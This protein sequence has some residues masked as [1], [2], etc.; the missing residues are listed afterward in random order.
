M[1]PAS[2]LSRGLEPQGAEVQKLVAKDLTNTQIDQ[3][4]FISPRT[5]DRQR[6]R[7]S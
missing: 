1:L 7:Y 2:R 4:L 6:S 5:V 3:E